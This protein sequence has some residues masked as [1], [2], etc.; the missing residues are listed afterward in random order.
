[1]Q[2]FGA[3]DHFAIDWGYRVIPGASTPDSERPV[4]DSLARRQERTPELRWIGDGEA[5]DPRIATEA[6]GDDPVRATRYG[7]ENIKRLAPMLIPAATTDGLD[8]YDRLRELYNDLVAQ[9][10][11]EVGHVAVVVGGTWQ[12]TKYAAQAG[13]VYTAVP[14]ARQQEAVRFLLENAFVTPAYLL[15][16]EVLRRIEPT[17]AVE[18]VRARQAAVLTTVLQ[19]ARLGRLADQSALAAPDTPPYTIADLFED[20][21]AGI[22]SEARQARA[23]PDEYRRNLQRTFV[24]RMARLMARHRRRRLRPRARR[25]MRGP[26]R[27]PRSRGWT[28]CSPPL[29]RTRAT[30]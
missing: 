21:S 22:F 30:S 17:G 29:H 15:D 12:E 23:T 27:G 24:E 19:N 16:P 25:P 10:A 6:L 14:R 26:S 20:L 13:P 7:L 9:W 3:Y 8:N 18:R 5:V 4:L 28:R 2:G 1:M 11:R